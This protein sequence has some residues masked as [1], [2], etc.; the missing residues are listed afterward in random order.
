MRLR[1][2][3]TALL[4]AALVA[5]AT[6]LAGCGGDDEPDS[7][8]S[9]SVAATGEPS[10]TDSSGTD[11]ATPAADDTDYLPVPDGVRLTPPGRELQLRRPAAVA[12]QPR[13]DV[14]A[15]ARV[16]ARRIQRSSVA[17]TLK[18]Y[19][20]AGS[21]VRGRTPYFVTFRVTNL[22]ETDLGGQQLPAYV[23]GS[24][25]RLVA[26]TGI[27][28]RFRPCPGST[29]PESFAPGDETTSCLIFLLPDDLEPDVVVVRPPEGVEPL[30]WRGAV[31]PYRA[32]DADRPRR[33]RDR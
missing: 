25:G 13:Q 19:D 29:F 9:E 33:G 16:E 11:A 1:A 7:A 5:G 2:V 27:D 21:A 10:A 24:D 8:P 31:T 18:G 30:M 17:A 26:P 14:V 15:V 6:G 28:R 23:V 32:P 4:V 22:G 20:L 12:W 3:P